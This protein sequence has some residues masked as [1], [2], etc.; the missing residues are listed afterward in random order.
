GVGS[1]VIQYQGKL[2][3]QHLK[4]L[5][6]IEK[7][8]GKQNFTVGIG[9]E[10]IPSLCQVL[11]YGFEAIDL[12]IADQA[13]ALQLKRLHA[14]RMQSHNCQTMKPQQ[15]AAYIDNAAFIGSTGDGFGEPFI[16]SLAVC[17]S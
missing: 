16:K 17:P 14:L 6:P 4:H 15:P 7:I 1:A 5:F 11:S 10:G 13:A 8:H 3:I 2:R 12:T 9:V